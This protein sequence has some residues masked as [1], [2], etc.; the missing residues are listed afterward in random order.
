MNIYI[1]FN[2]FKNIFGVLSIWNSWQMLTGLPAIS[3]SKIADLNFISSAAI[4][5]FLLIHTPW[6][7]QVLAH[8]LM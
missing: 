5:S 8:V 7:Q 3:R 1:L 6:R 4:S 2:S